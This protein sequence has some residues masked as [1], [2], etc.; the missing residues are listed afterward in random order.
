MGWL[1]LLGLFAG[2]LTTLAGLGGGLLMTLALS[3]L[4]D[5]TRALAVA[6]PALLVGNVH[7]VWLYRAYIQK[8]LTWTFVAGAFPGALVGGLLAVSLPEMVLR[9]LLVAAAGL[10]VA[11]ELELFR[12]RPGPRS[13]VPAS[14]AAGALTATS[15]GGGLLLG[16]LLLASGLKLERFVVTASLT[17]VSMHIARL[18]AYGAG[19]LVNAA[20]L[21]DAAVLAGCILAGNLL[22]RRGRGLLDEKRGH[23]L[24]WAVL[25]LCVV[26]SLAGL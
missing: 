26:L 2:A 21:R 12:W 18:A 25:M 16:P 6:A 1:I 23:T 15:G 7:R 11:R 8:R 13:A 17:A 24:T 4:W 5:P 19:G 22:G 3:L 20:T 10:A 9:V 14:F